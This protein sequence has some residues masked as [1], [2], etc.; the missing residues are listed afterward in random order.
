M[1]FFKII[2]KLCDFFFARVAITLDMHIFSLNLWVIITTCIARMS[3]KGG[4]EQGGLAQRRGAVLKRLPNT[5]HSEQSSLLLS[6]VQRVSKNHTLQKID[7]GRLFTRLQINVLQKSISWRRMVEWLWW[8]DF[9]CV[10]HM[11]A[12]PPA[13]SPAPKS[14]MINMNYDLNIKQER[15]YG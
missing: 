12:R 5:L 11:E 13:R 1:D 15:R 6:F 9:I 14:I 2:Q 10:G 7:S 3:W 4:Q 8:P